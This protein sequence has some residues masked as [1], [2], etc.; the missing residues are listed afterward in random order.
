MLQTAIVR[1]YAPH[2]TRNHSETATTP[3]WVRVI[4]LANRAPLRHDRTNGGDVRIS[5]SS[6]GLVTAI[7]PLVK[8]YGG[9]WI[10]HG[11]GSADIDM[12]SSKRI[13]PGVGY[14]LRYVSLSDDEYRGYY[15]GFANEGLWP[16]CHN[17]GVTPVFRPSDFIA[18]RV[19]NARFA[20]AAGREAADADSLVLV[21]DYH[22]ALAPR[23]LGRQNANQ[24]IVAFWHIPWPRPQV[25][26]ACPWGAE[27]VEGL[28]GSDIVGFQTE[29]DCLNF[30]S[31][32]EAL[33]LD[34]T[35]DCVQKRVIHRGSTT[36]ARVYPVGIKRQN[37]AV[38]ACPSVAV[39]RDQVRRDWGVP[40]EVRLGLGID[41]LDYTKGINQKFVAVERLLE[42][43][44]D[45]RG[46][47]VFAQIAEPSR[48]CLPAYQATRAELVATATRVNARFGKG[49]YKPIL[50]LEKRH[51]AGDVYRFYR[52]ADLCYVGSLHDGMN[53]VAKEFVEAREDEHGVLILS[54]FAGA[55]RQ[56]RAALLIN[57]H[58]TEA[59]ADALARGLEM[60]FVEQATRMR[61][62]RANVAAFDVTWWARQLM[63][64]AA[65]HRY[66]S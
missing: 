20:G 31:C 18:Y 1:E 62:L 14:R 39:C 54:E 6:G 22:F 51:D 23:L 57:P 35:V 4:V 50:L 44:P 21:Q 42:G 55:A 28:L 56:L 53:L 48:D 40:A 32:V 19:A 10:A 41:R 11:A 64:D 58:D 34:A 43:H 60:P 7:E 38:R 47:F 17:V 63:S 16:L 52:A 9:I 59:S 36:L 26:R 15:Y 37:D 3:R 46:H 12:N 65:R 33:V 45:W 49:A 2:V 27:L 8:D 61:V 13:M 29:E 66:R 24:T 25:F 5:R 30:L